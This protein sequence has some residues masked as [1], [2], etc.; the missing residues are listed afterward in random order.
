MGIL[1]GELEI[2]ADELSEWEMELGV[3]WILCKNE[4]DGFAVVLIWE[5]L[6]RILPLAVSLTKIPRV[7]YH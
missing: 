1:F 6:R 2:I 7:V 3:N 4:T 5:F